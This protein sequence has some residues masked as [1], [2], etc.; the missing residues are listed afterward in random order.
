MFETPEAFIHL[1]VKTAT[2]TNSAD[3]GGKIQISQNQISYSVEKNF[4]GNEYPF[5]ASL[6]PFYSNN[7]IC[8]TYVIQV[9][10]NNE[11]DSPE[12][13]SLI[14]IPNG[15]LKETYKDCVNAGKKMKKLN[16][17]GSKG[18]VRFLYKKADKFENLNENPS[19]IKIIFPEDPSE[20]LMKKYLGLKKL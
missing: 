12:I 13:I 9:I 5:K 6:P 16:K 10:H 3:F 20:L 4:R 14:S 18:D 7:K 1:E 19:R 11:K 17:L 15:L 2:D 8:L